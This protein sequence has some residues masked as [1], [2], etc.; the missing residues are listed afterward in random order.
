MEEPTRIDIKEFRELGLVAEINR[1]I[2]H[3]LGLALEVQVDDETGAESLG[4]VWDFRDDPEGI[5]Y[6]DGDAEYIAGIAV[7]AARVERIWAEREPARVEALG[8][9][10]QPVSHRLPA[11]WSS[12]YE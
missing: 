10:V 11:D 6:D 7:K 9:M 12:T 5:Y 1:R 3:P 4:G 8:Y 2:L